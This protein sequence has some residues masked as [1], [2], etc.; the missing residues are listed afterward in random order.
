[1]VEKE[2]RLLKEKKQREEEEK[3]KGPIITDELDKK[4]KAW[5]VSAVDERVHHFIHEL[6]MLGEDDP[7]V[8]NGVHLH[9]FMI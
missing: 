5:K 9:K 6:L 7:A 8:K 2:A 3:E 4:E 1:M